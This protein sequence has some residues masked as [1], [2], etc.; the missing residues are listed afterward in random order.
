MELR[1]AIIDC[2]PWPK[3]GRAVSRVRRC[4]YTFTTMANPALEQSFAGSRGPV[5]SLALALTDTLIPSSS[6][7]NTTLE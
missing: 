6:T 3:L 2:D 1:E 7:P 5:L 4:T